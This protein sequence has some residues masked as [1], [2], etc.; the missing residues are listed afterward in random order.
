MQDDR[1]QYL[2]LARH[3][4]TELGLKRV[5]V[6]RASSRYG[7]FG[8]GKFPRCLAPSGPSGGDG[9]DLPARRHG[10]RQATEGDPQ[11]APGRRFLVGD[12]LEAAAILK[13]MRAAGMKQR[14]FGAFRT[15]G[16]TLLKEA[17]DAAE[18]FEAVYPYDPTRNDRAGWTSTADSRTASTKSRSSLPRWPMTR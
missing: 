8:L 18:G 10:L 15:L 12:E 3:I 14:A 16:D 7:R 2:T 1:Q 17:G 4:Y 6:L 5:A 13:Q 9:A 11:L